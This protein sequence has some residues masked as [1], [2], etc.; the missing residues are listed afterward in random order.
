MGKAA[1]S[2]PQFEM[3]AAVLAVNMQIKISQELYTISLADPVFLGDSEIVPRMIARNDPADLLI[4][5]VTCIMEIAELTSSGSWFWCPGTL[6][7]A[8]LL[9]RT[10][11]TMEKINSKFWLRG[12]FL[13]LAEADWLVKLCAS[14]LTSHDPAV[15]INRIIA[16]PL[17]PLSDLL[18]ELLECNQSF[19]K[20][21]NSLC[22]IQKGCRKFK[23]SV[24]LLLPWSK[25]RNNISTA[26]ISCF[27]PQAEVF[28]A[29]N[30]LKHLD[31]QPQDGIYYVSDRS[32]RS[33]IGVPLICAKPSL[34][35]ALCRTH[36]TS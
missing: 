14:L 9:T 6:N 20:V 30:K 7:P 36:M 5:Y 11:S 33:K 35:N 23:Q 16:T 13:S 21:L 17:N 19:S 25:I 12:S 28:L 4:F 1:F 29:Q 22:I 34:L 31:I 15:S 32:F 8:D 27:S 10:G 24:N 3:A 2:A 26:I 18:V